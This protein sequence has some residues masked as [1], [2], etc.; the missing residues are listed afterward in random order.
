LA[1]VW[2]FSS[3]GERQK[4]DY[5]VLILDLKIDDKINYIYFR[6]L[7]VKCSL[8][9]CKAVKAFSMN[10]IFHHPLPLNKHAKSASGIRPLRML[11]AF[12]ALG[13]QIDLVTGYTAERKKCIAKIKENIKQGKKYD[14]VYSE[15]S[16]MPTVLTEPHHLPLH[17]LVDWF[18]F[19]F[20]KQNNMPIGLFYRDIYWL[21]DSYGDGL[22][23]VKTL[24][25]KFAYRCDLW[26]YQRTLTKLYLPSLEMGCYVPRVDPNIF[27]ALP[28]GHNS[29]ELYSSSFSEK[30]PLRLFY[31]GGLSNHYQLHK[32][33]E[34]VSDLPKIELTIC[35]R[36]AE[37]LAIKHEYPKPTSN[38][39]IVHKSGSNMEAHL[40][41]CDVAVLFVKP[42]E[43]WE[44]AS[45][46]KL[47]EYLGFHKPILASEGTLAGQ[48]VH[49]KGV[50]WTVQ[51]DV[52]E[53]KAL[54]AK[55]LSNPEM[56][57]PVLQ[58]LERIG[59]NHSWQARA[60]QVIED[61]TS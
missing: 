7:I 59:P 51:Y 41:A 4:F 29:P 18:F 32:L 35:T 16:T 24:I 10:I 33:F 8:F 54:L 14:F 57:V 61:L 52:Q 22:N 25:A 12:E 5:I 50:G 1:F 47:Y 40:R 6:R 20:C 60:K 53:V 27:E 13:C 38:I 3:F 34:A 17:P 44:F 31:V 46:V 56:R 11:A 21:F 43:Y 30:R 37:W 36:E 9:C 45:P 48:F 58:N 2:C 23:P 49:E 28:P 42:Q 15:S 26:V 19:R 39:K 55:L